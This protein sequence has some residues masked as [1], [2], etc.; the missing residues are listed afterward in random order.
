MKFFQVLLVTFLLLSAFSFAQ[1]EDMSEMKSQLQEMENNF[2]KDM[3]AGD[4]S[5]MLDMYLDDAVSLP[6]YSPMMKGKD[7]IK[8][9]MDMEAKSGNKTTDF[10]ITTT[11]VFG[12][13]DIIVEIGT[14]EM[15]MQIKG[16]NDPVNDHGKYMTVYE[17]Q[18]DGSL[19]IKS[20][21]WNSDINPWI[22][23]QGNKDKM[24]NDE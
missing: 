15:T 24:K 19:K 22:P 10:N 12:S 5:K 2:A 3:M 13:G 18:D 7:A 4:N 20:D 16:M 6:S 23:Q 14:Y 8:K 1:I 9:A 17:E 11:D 21:T